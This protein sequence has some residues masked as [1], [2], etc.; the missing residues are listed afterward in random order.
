[1]GFFFKRKSAVQPIQYDPQRQQP[2][3]R[4]S[5]CTGEAVGGLLDKRSG[6]FHEIQLIRDERDRQEFC[7]RTG[8]TPEELKTIY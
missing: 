6:D 1:M 4:K 7:Q 3:I 2:A 8:V 5:I